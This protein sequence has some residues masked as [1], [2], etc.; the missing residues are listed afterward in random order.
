[1]ILAISIIISISR[2]VYMLFYYNIFNEA[3]IAYVELYGSDCL[4]VLLKII[5][6]LV[7]LSNI[8]MFTHMFSCII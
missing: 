2:S 7:C 8:D 4:L 5:D 6:L 3:I 1:M